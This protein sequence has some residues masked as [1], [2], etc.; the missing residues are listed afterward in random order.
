M[1]DFSIKVG[2]LEPAIRASL[3]EDD[4]T[5]INLSDAV[6]VYFVMKKPGEATAKV[7]AAG[8][9]DDALAGEVSYSWSGTDTD[10]SGTYHAE[11]RVTFSSGKVRHVPSGGYLTIEV[12]ETL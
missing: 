4:G 3:L 6:S 11:W 2:D 9:I 8:S 1:A 12:L 10:A 5:Q 7:D